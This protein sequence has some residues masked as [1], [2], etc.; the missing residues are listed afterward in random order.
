MD[1]TPPNFRKNQ[2][3][4]NVKNKGSVESIQLTHLGQKIDIDPSLIK[5][6]CAQAAQNAYHCGETN[7]EE[8]Y[9]EDMEA[10]ITDIL[11]KKTKKKK[12]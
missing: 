2:Q 6:A 11:K 12:R 9:K 5:E 4:N 7:D 8:R 1:I 3:G 10:L